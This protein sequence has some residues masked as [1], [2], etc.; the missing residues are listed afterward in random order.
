MSHYK[1]LLTSNQRFRLNSHKGFGFTSQQK[2]LLFA[3]HQRFGF[4]FHRRMGFLITLYFLLL[5]SCSFLT[6][7]VV[8]TNII[9]LLERA[10]NRKYH[11]HSKDLTA[12]AALALF[13]PNCT[14]SKSA[15]EIIH[16]HLVI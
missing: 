3:F 7:W 16:R 9:A 12:S 5:E 4:M 8:R 11:E 14:S 1:F 6:S 13:V 10:K 15:L 2:K